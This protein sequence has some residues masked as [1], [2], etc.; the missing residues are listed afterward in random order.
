MNLHKDTKSFKRLIAIVSQRYDINPQFIEKD[1]WITLILQNLAN[2]KYANS[3]VFKGGT[4]LSKGYNI[5]FRFS[6][7]VDIA[8]CHSE[9][10]SGN[11]V[12]STIRTIEKDITNELNEIEKAGITSKGSKFRKSIYGYDSILGKTTITN[13]NVIIEI[14]SFA[15]PYP[16]SKLTIESFI[17]RYLKEINDTDSIIEYGL[18]DF[19]LYVLDKR[20]T[21]IEKLVSLVRFSQLGINGLSSKIRHFYDL[22]FLLQDRECLEYINSTQFKRDFDAILIH[23]KEIFEDPTGWKDMDINQIPLFCDTKRVWSKLAPIYTRELQGLAFA[24][25]PTEDKVL[26][27]FTQIIS[28]LMK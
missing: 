16:F 11:K 12:K 6:E 18:Q 2:N 15:N 4:S 14:N 26:A 7:D 27:S 19:E 25:I 28:A 23:D 1:Y 24:S 22:H 9:E 20:Q 5:I 13:H 8:L 10:M 17:S 3:A 21:M